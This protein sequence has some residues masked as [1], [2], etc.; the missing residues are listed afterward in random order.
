MTMPLM[1]KPLS[2]GGLLRV[3]YAALLTVA[4]V[5]ALASGFEEGFADTVSWLVVIF[6]P[7]ILVCLIWK[8]HVLPEVIAEKR[9]HPQK[10]AIKVLCI[11]SLLFGGLLWPFAWLW[12]YSKPVGYRLAYGRD[13]H[14]DHY[15]ALPPESGESH[16][17]AAVLREQIAALE[18]R[19]AA[20]HASRAP[21]ARDA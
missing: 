18:G 3:S 16:E 2:A 21:E 14:D 20:I 19:L 1:N 8:V 17:A 10:E 4:P 13:K 12:A 11:M 5:S 7:I 6:V 9:Q 15:M